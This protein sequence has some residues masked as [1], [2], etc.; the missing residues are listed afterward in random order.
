[1]KG[2]YW[3]TEGHF[4]VLGAWRILDRGWRAED[5]ETNAEGREPFSES[6]PFS[7]D[8][9]S[10]MMIKQKN[11]C[12]NKWISVHAKPY[13][14]LLNSETHSTYFTD[15]LQQ[16]CSHSTARTFFRRLGT[17]PTVLHYEAQTGMS[18]P[19]SSQNPPWLQRWRGQQPGRNPHV[20][21]PTL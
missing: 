16:W 11:L 4:S 2:G 1:M 8:W 13:S 14:K 5:A 6:G 17:L 10:C 21:G 12:A 9:N 7:A 3:L 20:E 15:V 18:G 19:R